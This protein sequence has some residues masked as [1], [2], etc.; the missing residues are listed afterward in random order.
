MRVDIVPLLK[1][2]DRTAFTCG[3]APLDQYIQKQ[4]SQDIKRKLATCFVISDENN[5]VIGYYT[6]SSAGI[7]KDIVPEAISKKMPRAYKELPVTLLGRLAVDQNHFKKGLGKIL[8]VSALK[9]SLL[10]SA[11]AVASMAVVVVPIDED[12]KLFYEKFGFISLEGSN[13]MFLPMST[14]A[15]AFED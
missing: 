2:H 7:P 11:E 4:V 13:R 12:A 5:A 15:R 1:K 3:K 14:I 9:K 8:L 10:A 6:L